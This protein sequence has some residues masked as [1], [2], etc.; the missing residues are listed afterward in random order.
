MVDLPC[1]TRPGKL[2]DTSVG[3]K[4]RDQ[5]I[6]GRYRHCEGLVSCTRSADGL[7]ADHMT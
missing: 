3:W 5:V 2:T 7:N 4:A 6:I 1:R